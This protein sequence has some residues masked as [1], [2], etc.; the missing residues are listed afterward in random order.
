[1]ND[2]VPIERFAARLQRLGLGPFV[3]GLLEAGGEP[4][5]FLVAQS[6][7][8]TQPALGLFVDEA[9]LSGLARWLEDPA[10]LPALA[11]TV[12]HDAT[13]E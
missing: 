7:Y 6:L 2:S 4:L 8:L 11:E 5:G 9:R 12:R 1:M 10:S 3:A 13:K